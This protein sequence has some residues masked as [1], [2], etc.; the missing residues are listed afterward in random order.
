M[1]YSIISL[2]AY[3]ASLLLTD[4]EKMAEVSKALK[5]ALDKDPPFLA[6][7][8]HVVT[9]PVENTRV[10]NVLKGLGIA[11]NVVDNALVANDVY[12]YVRRT[13]TEIE[14]EKPDDR[15]Y[16]HK[17]KFTGSRKQDMKKASK[18]ERDE[19]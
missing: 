4:A 14:W 18:D 5:E 10:T 6:K 13:E 9:Q 19:R 3:F 11:Y 12:D 7:L 17:T 2:G 15:H 8:S 16:E 1:F